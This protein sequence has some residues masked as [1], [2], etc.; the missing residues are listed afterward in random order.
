MIPSWAT[1]GRKVVCI[2]SFENFNL[3]D[4]NGESWPPSRWGY[5]MP[6]K[7]TTYTLLHAFTCSDGVGVY[8]AE[9]RN[10]HQLNADG[11]EVGFPI[12]YFRPVIT[13]E[14]DMLTFASWLNTVPA[15]IK[16]VEA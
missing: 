6:V 4:T 14:E 15:D 3:I 9:V 16:E 12:E 11:R 2:E 5:N 10:D 8:L 13:L 1:P 7:G